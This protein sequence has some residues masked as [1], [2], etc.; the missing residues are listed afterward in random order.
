MPKRMR[1]NS[2]GAAAGVEMARWS[3]EIVRTGE[4]VVWKGEWNASATKL[5]RARG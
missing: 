4:R 2:P 3:R 5:G 1:S